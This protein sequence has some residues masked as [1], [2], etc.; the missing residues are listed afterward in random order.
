MNNVPAA[1]ITIGDELLI[2]QVIDTNSA[3]IAKQLNELGIDVL[4]RV[5]VGDSKAAIVRALDEE[6]A[7]ASLLIITGGLGPTS[8]DI[9]KPL[10]TDYFGGKLVADKQ[11]EDHIRHI[12][13][14]RK[15]PLAESN[16]SQALVPDTC[17]VLHNKMGTAPGMW[18]DKDDKVII[19]LPGVPHEMM[20][21]MEE[22]ALPLLRQRFISDA[23]FHRSMITAGEGE[24]VIA[25]RVK[26]L[27]SALPHYIKLAYLPEAGGVK[28]RLTGR[29]PDKQRLSDELQLRVEEFANR[30]E[31][32][33]VSLDDIPM[34]L[35][36]GKWLTIHQKTLGLA[37]S[38]TGGNVA[39]R[40]TQ[41]MGSGGYFV[42]SMVCYNNSVKEQQLGV[43]K[44]SLE[45]F[46]AVSEEVAIEMAQG[47]LKAL[48]SDYVMAVTGQLS[49]GGE[50]DGV[51]VGTVWIAVGD[52]QGIKTK[53][54]RFPYD[55]LRNKEMATAMC[56]LLIWKFI[57]GRSF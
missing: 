33:I 29:G 19:A 27:E 3:W 7:S 18:F 39:H 17:T 36:I 30:L 44:A 9:T 37:E 10:L 11:T 49:A 53:R 6:L 28:L 1:I 24:S 38:C 4:R 48:G 47:A 14:V 25:E 32:I 16:L 42:G 46:T 2:G 56:L 15:R 31:D 23:I 26:D 8:D 12:F 45:K 34:E 22:R 54:V 51:E 5:A 43:K 21:I 20:H 41:V 50:S 57:H 55:R 13:T 35:I 40:M 52:K